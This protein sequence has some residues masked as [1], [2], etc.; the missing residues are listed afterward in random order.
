MT[1]QTKEFKEGYTAYHTNGSNHNPYSYYH[2]P[3]KHTDWS[4]GFYEGAKEGPAKG[5]VSFVTVEDVDNKDTD[6]DDEYGS[7]F[8]KWDTVSY[9]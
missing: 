3:E 8:D 9:T 5:F 1:Y 2:D 6:G 7:I 4:D